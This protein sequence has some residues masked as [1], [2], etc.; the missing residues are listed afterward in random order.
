MADFVKHSYKGEYSPLLRWTNFTY[1]G[2]TYRPSPLRFRLSFEDFW[3]SQDDISGSLSLNRN[4]GCPQRRENRQKEPRIK[5]SPA[6]LSIQDFRG[7]SYPCASQ[8]LGQLAISQISL[9]HCIFEQIAGKRLPLAA[10]PLFRHSF[11]QKFSPVN[12]HNGNQTV[13]SAC[14][15][16]SCYITSAFLSSFLTPTNFSCLYLFPTCGPPEISLA[17]ASSGFNRLDLRRK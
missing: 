6:H 5:G 14:F 2:V 8:Q 17:T 4:F 11:P 13:F 10:R 16:L 12:R 1:V 3:R 9:G 7:N 15:L